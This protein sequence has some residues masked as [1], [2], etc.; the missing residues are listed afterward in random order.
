M[1]GARLGVAAGL[2]TLLVLGGGSASFALWS[3]TSSVS[4]TSTAASVGVGHALSGSTLAVTYNAS[5]T[6][7]VGVVT[8][9]N[10]STRAGTY[11]VSISATS[12]SSTLRSA[13]AVEVG[14]AAT[15]TAAAVLSG[16][17]SGTFAAT[18][19][20][21]AAIG[22]GA[23]V[24]LC[25]RTSM[26][27]ANITA[28]ASSALAATVATSVTV[29]TWSASAS[30]AITFSQ[31]VAASTATING[32]AWYW[33]RSTLN[34]ALCLENRNAAVLAGTPTTQGTCEGS[35]VENML[36]NELWHFAATDS[37]YYRIV[38]KA[39]PTM[40]MGAA[41]ASV[42]TAI[43]LSTS[44]NNQAEWFATLN[45]DGTYSFQMRSGGSRCIGVIGAATT[46]P[47]DL[48]LANCAATAAQKF[49]LVVLENV[50]A[51]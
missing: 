6:T 30:P 49:T 1:T 33:I 46:A 44:A 17:V 3:A 38:S 13:V 43:A 28:N 51:P 8:V 35:S 21:S 34:P 48:A 15:C 19:T 36:A 39:V 42:G 26:T 27:S 45:A 4:S 29:G 18:V 9:T 23:S 14:T 5:T 31:A 50:A 41:N 47:T 24:A 12:A 22:A 2:T 7:G 16:T 37:G 40:W 20:T 11:T 25:V 32:S 10:S